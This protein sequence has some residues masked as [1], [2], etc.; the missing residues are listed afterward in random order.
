M[1]GYAEVCKRTGSIPVY[2]DEEPTVPF[3]FSGKPA[4]SPDCPDGYALTSFG[5]PCTV[6]EKLIRDRD[7][8]IYVS[9]PKLK[10]H[11][12]T[13]VS[14]GVKNQWGFPPHADRGPDGARA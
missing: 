12:L 6:A 7:S 8:N 5:M 1:T 3:E 11:T 4:A 9:M 2:L 14:F 10:T 13:G